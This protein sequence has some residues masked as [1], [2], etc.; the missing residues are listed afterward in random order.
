MPSR[1]I[2]IHTLTNYAASLLNR[3]DAGF[4]K[5]MPFGGAVRTRISSQCLKRH[6]RTHDGANSLAAIDAPTSVRSRV[7]FDRYIVQPL[8]TDGI[9]EAVA[10]A[11]AEKIVDVVFGSEAKQ[12][13][14]SKKKE[15]KAS[16]ADEGVAAAASSK[17]VATSQVTVVGRPE[18]DYLYGLALAACREGGHDAAAVEKKLDA[19][20][21]AK[22]LKANLKALKPG[23]LEAGLGAAL[24]GRMVTG[25]ILARTDAAIRCGPRHDGT[26]TDGRE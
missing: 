9:D 4:A 26:W 2:Q 22:D 13:R 25:D 11:T 5:R 10:R 23:S 6:W 18:L 8:I 21:K 12:A 14:A 1:F 19:L 7:A 16:G 3:D 15:R 24:F 20:L 17:V